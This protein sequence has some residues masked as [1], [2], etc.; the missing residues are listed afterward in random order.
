MKVIAAGL[1]ALSSVAAAEHYEPAPPPP[2]GPPKVVLPSSA[3]A[4][5]KPADMSYPPETLS[6]FVDAI[7]LDKAGNLER[8]AR[9]Y[10]DANEASEQANTYY[11]LGDV[12]RRRERYKDALKAYAKYLELAPTAADRKEV[13]R[14]ITEIKNTP[15]VA[16]IDGDDPDAL[17]LVDNVLIGPSPVVI[18]LA[19]GYH[20]VD[21]ITPMGYRGNLVEAKPGAQEHLIMNPLGELKVAGNVVM[22]GSPA[23]GSRGRWRDKET[24]IEYHLPGRFQLAP[25]HYETVLWEAGRACEKIVFDVPKTKDLL[26]VYLDAKPPAKPGGCIPIKLRT[27]LIRMA[28][29]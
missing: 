1:L 26:Y 20:Q 3:P 6:L 10:R 9:T 4:K 19:S 2:P 18:Q 22:S 23:I 12:E 27:Q 25:G 21:R 24:G 29:P 8:A 11:N 5:R 28:P 14:T 17:V 16:V 15:Y 13:E 7:M